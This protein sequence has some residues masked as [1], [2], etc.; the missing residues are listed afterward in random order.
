VWDKVRRQAFFEISELRKLVAQHA[1]F[2]AEAGTAEPDTV[3]RIAMGATLNSFYGGVEN[4]FKRIA[5][6]IDHK[7][8]SGE[9]WHRDLLMAMAQATADRPPVISQELMEELR[10]FLS[11]RHIF[12]AGYVIN[13]KW[14]RMAHLAFACEQ[15]LDQ[16]IAEIQ[17]FFGGTP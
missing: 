11:F 15:T 8:P 16:F 17:S 12:R 6:G 7:V 14:E 13:L 2:L 9:S 3:H 10:E 4:I 1:G 5:K